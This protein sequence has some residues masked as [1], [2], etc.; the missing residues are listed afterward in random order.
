MTTATRHNTLCFRLGTALWVSSS[1]RLKSTPSVNSSCSE[2]C[3]ERPGS[4]SAKAG[5]LRD[6]V[7]SSTYSY[8]VTKV[9]IYM[10]MVFLLYYIYNSFSMLLLCAML[11]ICYCT[12][13]VFIVYWILDFTF[14]L[15]VVNFLAFHNIQCITIISCILCIMLSG[16]CV[17]SHKRAQLVKDLQSTAINHAQP[18]VWYPSIFFIRRGYNHHTV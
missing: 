3:A 18:S 12:F 16:D 17:F 14:I 13:S 10:Y 5:L 8:N 6:L 15:Y 1:R 7:E 2:V 11:Y 4:S 9:I